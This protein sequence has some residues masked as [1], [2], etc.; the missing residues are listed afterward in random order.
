MCDVTILGMDAIT[1]KSV[2][3]IVPNAASV[4]TTP[5]APGPLPIAYPVVGSSIWGDDEPE[6]RSRGT[7]ALTSLTA[8][9]RRAQ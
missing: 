1:E 2:H 6:A 4:C 7:T 8:P 5:A 3:S 9:A